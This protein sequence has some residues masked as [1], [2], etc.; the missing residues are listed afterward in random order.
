MQSGQVIALN[1]DGSLA[2]PDRPLIPVLAGDGVGPEVWAATA[3]V[4]E[5]AVH[6]AYGASRALAWQ[7]TG[8]GEASSTF[9]AGRVALKGPLAPTTEASLR[10]ELGL[11]TAVRPLRWLPGVPAALARPEALDVI[12]VCDAHGEQ[13]DAWPLGDPAVA[14]LVDALAARGQGLPAE[15]LIEARVRDQAAAQAV[16]GQALKLAVDRGIERVALVHGP[17]S[18]QRLRAWGYQ[19]AQRD[20]GPIAV[21]ES[22]F[23]AD[24]GGVL[25]ADKRLVVG[26]RLAE[27]LLPALLASPAD[28]GVIA[29]LDDAAGSLEAICAALIGGSWV[30][31]GAL[32]G[33]GLAIFEATH[34]ADPRSAGQDRANPASLIGAGELLLRHL[35]WTEAADN[36]KRGLAGAMARRT[37]TADL[38]ARISGSTLRTCSEFG[39]DVIENM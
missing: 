16:A 21:A 22:D 7:A 3:P 37:V 10:V 36:V 34:E 29:A 17:G 9:R 26:A 38:H 6:A 1:A 8:V 19:I 15:G 35:G 13:A 5:A 2:V 27:D 30:L 11:R 28:F 25:P 12:F 20:F 39:S 23:H 31:P 24:F 4:L 33:E 32:F 14:S 18:G